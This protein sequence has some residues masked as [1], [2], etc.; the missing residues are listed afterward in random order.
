MDP[1]EA[2]DRERS[3]LRSEG[4]R[5]GFHHLRRWLGIRIYGIYARP[6]SPPDSEPD[7]P[8]F[9]GRI[10]E[11]RDIEEL[12]VLTKRPELGMPEAFVRRALAKGDVCEAV[13]HKGE[14]VSYCW[15]AFT[16]THDSDGVYVDFGEHDRYAYK[17]FTLPQFRGAHLRRYYNP[18][19]D[20]YCISRGATHAVAFVD[21]SNHAAILSNIGMGN[22]RIGFAGYLKRGRLFIPFRTPAVRRRGFRFFVPPVD[23]SDHDLIQPTSP[24]L[25]GDCS[26]RRGP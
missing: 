22:R 18:F 7:L 26:N 25:Q 6:L 5:I 15:M 20:A 11:A 12:L 19:T 23:Q 21:V 24:R 8:E 17:G 9:S 13:L 16:P 1:K 4:R 10:Y 3:K 14:I 2:S